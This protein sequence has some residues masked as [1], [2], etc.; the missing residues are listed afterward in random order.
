MEERGV[1]W[2]GRGLKEERKQNRWMREWETV[3]RASLGVRDVWCCW[4]ERMLLSKLIGSLVACDMMCVRVREVGGWWAGLVW[5]VC[6]VEGNSKLEVKILGSV[7]LF[8]VT[9]LSIC[10]QD[11]CNLNTYSLFLQ[12]VSHQQKKSCW[13][14]W[15][16]RFTASGFKKI[17]VEI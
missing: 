3:L 2:I 14:L 16:Q 11:N 10:E 4:M 1:S 17:A 15:T 6:S 9:Y 12:P 7:L 5:Y 13:L 8:R